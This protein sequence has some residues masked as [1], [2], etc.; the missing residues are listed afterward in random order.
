MNGTVVF[1]TAIIILAVLFQAPYLMAWLV[2]GVAVA[3]FGAF[4]PSLKR[5]PARPRPAEDE[6]FA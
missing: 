3:A 6:P 5:S 2:A 4:G 1:G